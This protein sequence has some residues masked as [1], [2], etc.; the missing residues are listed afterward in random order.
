M[1]AVIGFRCSTRRKQLDRH[2]CRA[3]L[4]R[5]AGAVPKPVETRKVLRTNCLHMVLAWKG[6]GSS[7]DFCAAWS[8]LA[9]PKPLRFPWKGCAR[10][11]DAPESGGPNLNPKSEVG[12]PNPR[13]E[14][15]WRPGFRPLDFRPAGSLVSTGAANRKKVAKSG[16]APPRKRW[17]RIA[18]LRKSQQA[19]PLQ[20]K[21]RQPNSPMKP[22]LF[23]C[24]SRLA[25]MLL[26]GSATEKTDD[27]TLC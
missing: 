26:S 1:F 17:L 25:S 9:T 11:G 14:L 8:K 23:V 6:G 27:E 3:W 13:I 16:S 24:P 18:L 2:G 4:R 12:N 15:G 19:A 5:E 21:T 7:V 22:D 10:P 20:E